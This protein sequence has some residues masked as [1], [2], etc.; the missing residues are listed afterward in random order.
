MPKHSLLTEAT[1]H[2]TEDDP[3]FD[4]VAVEL[5]GPDGRP[6]DAPELVELFERALA[7]LAAGEDIVLLTSDAELTPAEAGRMLG[8][9]RQYVDR[10]ID[11][12]DLPAR[13]LP[14]SRHRRLRTADVLAYRDARV[15]GQARISEAINML[16][17]AGVEY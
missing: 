4:G 16:I 13:T 14:G 9:S 17:D 8:Y 6:V 11:L 12:G 7:R 1:V 15:R 3:S 10:L 5:R 2:P